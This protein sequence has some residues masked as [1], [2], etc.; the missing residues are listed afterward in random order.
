M[1][2]GV[3]LRALFALALV[4]LALGMVVV[5]Y[6]DAVMTHL[7]AR[8]AMAAQIKAGE[9]PF[10][11]PSQSCGQPLAGNPNFGTFFPDTILFLLLPPGAAF[12]MRFALAALLAF[13]GARRWA[14]AEGV[15]PPA[16]EVAGY[17]FALSGVF[18]SAW[19][20]YNTGLALALAPFVLAAVARACRQPA[21]GRGLRRA[22]SG[23]A[24][25][26]A[27]ELLAGEPV[28]ALLTAVAVAVR[29]V[30]HA[31]GDD[32]DGHPEPARRAGA[33]LAA[34]ALALLIAAP[35][36][37]VTWQSFRGSTRDVAPFS[38]AVATGTS[39]HAARMLEQ[40]TPFPFGR[41]DL[42]GPFGFH[43]HRFYDNH[44]PYLWTLHLGW[45]TL[46]LLLRH[47][48][49]L[50]RGERVWWMAA[51]AGV[52][53]SLGHQLPAARALSEVLSLGGRVRFPVKWWYLVALCL[54]VPVA[55]A[56]SRLYEG[57]GWDRRRA[58]AGLL[59]AAAA[60]AALP[61]IDLR[62]PLTIVT[63]VVSVVAAA[64]VSA[65]RAHQS[66]LLPWTVAGSLAI[67]H[68]PLVL[69]FVDRM[70]TPPPPLAGGRVYE[71][72]TA[73]AHPVG[74]GDA[75]G[76]TRDFFRRA[77]PELWAVAGGIG[78][79]GYAFDR[80]P[81]GSYFDGDR[82][83]R[84]AVDD[85]PWPERA[86]EL[87]RAGVRYVVTGES[88]AA[89]YR[90]LRTQGGAVLYELDAPSPPV[91]IESATT[92]SDPAGR[93]VAVRER[94]SGL[95]ATVETATPAMLVWSRTFFPAW[96][97]SVDGAPAPVV[98]AGGHLVGV[99]VPPGAHRVKVW[100]PAGPLVAGLVLAVLGLLI[101]AVLGRSQ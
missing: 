39:V 87:R 48:R 11:H 65:M 28:V 78:G 50:A 14:R 72:L 15:S 5:T 88:L 47:G 38:F 90:A 49:P 95:E 40:V 4:P 85:L 84:K 96:R 34:A 33:I 21:E 81:D 1:S 64:L 51:A 7:P 75:F 27:L 92:A 79:I 16:A 91:R 29:F 57:G 10:L 82:V 41:P 36:I 52:V 8:V 18:V 97:A 61:A 17:A 13:V 55:R 53:L 44:A 54:V 3:A 2:G 62:T 98:V 86:P 73:D 19:R 71:R 67:A 22:T 25:W 69:A 26:S 59:I 46:A 24:V 74:G 23:I 37:A 100:W 43:G 93:V 68:L 77:T 94:A 99:P 101:T 42:T 60:L 32:G 6:Q 76:T 35:Q 89:P 31:V 45:A 66:S 20:F 80:D 12:G 56:A 58:A 30:A 83:V 63:V 9:F 70:P